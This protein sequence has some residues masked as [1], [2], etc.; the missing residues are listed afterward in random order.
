MLNTSRRD[1]ADAVS[2]VTG[3]TGHEFRPDVLGDGDA[4]PLI[5]SLTREG[6]GWTTSWRVLLVLPA[7]EAA[8]AA[9]LEAIAQDLTDALQPVAAVDLIE[10]VTIKT[11]AGDLAGLQIT[12]RSD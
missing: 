12:A 8:A 6:A 11:Q 4:W 5:A 3:V 7:D 9:R 10:P 2:S 1:I